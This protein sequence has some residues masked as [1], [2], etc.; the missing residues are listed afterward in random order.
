MSCERMDQLIRHRRRARPFGW[1]AP[2]VRAF[3]CIGGIAMFVAAD[4]FE[5]ASHTFVAEAQAASAGQAKSAPRQHRAKRKSSVPSTPRERRRARLAA[6]QKKFRDREKAGA[7][8]EVPAGTQVIKAALRRHDARRRPT[9]RAT[10]RHQGVASVGLPLAG[11][12]SKVLPTE[13]GDTRHAERVQE[14]RKQITG[15]LARQARRKLTASKNLAATSAPGTTRGER[16]KERR[17][18]RQARLY[19]TALGRD[20]TPDEITKLERE[21]HRD[22]VRDRI[23]QSR[24]SLNEARKVEAEKRANAKKEHRRRQE[25]ARVRRNFKEGRPPR[26][27]WSK[28]IKPPRSSAHR[29]G[30]DG[31]RRRNKRFQWMKAPG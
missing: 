28:R 8:R 12:R 31:T 24:D 23:K 21:E 7:V 16:V 1:L 26:E 4:P 2:W 3:L 5:I 30:A 6:I 17:E 29:V 14:V 22:R 27:A 20:L 19:E 25:L 13:N 15:A 9:T 18:K 11:A 10:D